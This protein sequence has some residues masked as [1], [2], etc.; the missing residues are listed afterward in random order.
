MSRETTLLIQ[1]ADTTA[2]YAVRV[3][4]E[5]VPEIRSLLEKTDWRL[6][7]QGQL[8]LHQEN[9]ARGLGYIL[10]EIRAEL[11]SEINWFERAASYTT[12]EERAG[13]LT[14][15]RQHIARLEAFAARRQVR[16]AG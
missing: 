8:R 16:I 11:Q 2:I 4:P 7:A 5:D 3:L 6:L 15:L 9:A 13:T 14:A 10:G 1:Q 12:P